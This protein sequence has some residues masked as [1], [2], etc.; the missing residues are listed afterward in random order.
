[1]KKLKIIIELDEL[2]EG[3]VIL[4]ATQY[5]SA[6]FEIYH[7]L[8]RTWKHNE[9]LLTIDTLRGRIAE[10]LDEHGINVNELV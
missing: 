3:K 7:N 5:Q 6:L 8:W 10:V 4:S 9:E 2:A 1:V